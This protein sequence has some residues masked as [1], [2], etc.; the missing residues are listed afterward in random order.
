METLDLNLVSDAIREV[1]HRRL[2]SVVNASLDGVVEHV[3]F[4]ATFGGI[5]HAT[6]FAVRSATH[7]AVDADIKKQIDGNP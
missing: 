1:A 2:S 3:V 5:L 4:N 7:A 6:D